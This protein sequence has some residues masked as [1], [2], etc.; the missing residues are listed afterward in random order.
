MI[1]RI[2]SQ[3]AV[4]ID[5]SNGTHWRRDERYTALLHNAQF[6]DANQFE[7]QPVVGKSTD[8]KVV[9]T[10]GSSGR[11]R[12]N[13]GQLHEYYNRPGSNE[14]TLQ[15]NPCGCWVIQEFRFNLP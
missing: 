7:F 12:D 10:T 6:L 9:F 1:R 2:F 5:V 4:I 8:D 15:K 11:L 3:D 14:W 13:E